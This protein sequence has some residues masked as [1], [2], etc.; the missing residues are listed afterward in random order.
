MNGVQINCKMPRLYCK[1]N[2]FYKHTIF[3]QHFSITPPPCGRVAIKMRVF[4][5]E[6]LATCVTMPRFALAT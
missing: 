2:L 3:C 1:N 6:A 4:M 5:R